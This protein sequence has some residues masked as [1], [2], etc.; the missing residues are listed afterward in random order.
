M[1]PPSVGATRENIE[2][3]TP[4]T[5]ASANCFDKRYSPSKPGSDH[6][7]KDD[8]ERNAMGSP[9]RIG[10][11]PKLAL[12]TRRGTRFYKVPSL[13]GVWYRG[14]FEHNASVATLEDWFDPARIY[15]TLAAV[16]HGKTFLMPPKLRLP[17]FQD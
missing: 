12:T 1:L 7:A 6:R 8:I 13:R 11:D 14:P 9:R 16:G 2:A 4:P 15:D 17:I 3:G 5:L 10:T